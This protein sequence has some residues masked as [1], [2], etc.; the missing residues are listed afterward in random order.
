MKKEENEP[1]VQHSYIQMAGMNVMWNFNIKLTPD[2][3]KTFLQT[4]GTENKNKFIYY[5]FIYSLG[6]NNWVFFFPIKNAQRKTT[7]TN[8]F[9]IFAE[10][11][12]LFNFLSLARWC[13]GSPAREVLGKKIPII[14]TVVSFTVKFKV[15]ISFRRR[16]LSK[17]LPRDFDYRLVI[18]LQG[19]VKIMS[20]F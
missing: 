19:S 13:A 3:L 15:L 11:L 8:A 6:T 18:C 10:E 9:W 2:L 7:K 1:C 4:V 12:Y 17:D 5:T 16:A 20:V 14:R